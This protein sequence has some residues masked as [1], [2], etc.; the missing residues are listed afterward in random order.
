MTDDE[1]TSIG[2]ESPDGLRGPASTRAVTRESPAWRR[3][4]TAI[5]RLFRALDPYRGRLARLGVLSAIAVFFETLVLA[6]VVPLAGAISAN[7]KSLEASLGGVDLRISTWWLIGL[8]TSAVFVKLALGL[9]KGYAEARLLA[10]YEREQRLR[11][12]AAFLSS[13]WSV[14]SAEG[15]GHLQHVLTS[16]I[17]RCQTALRSLIGV[18]SAAAGL[19]VMLAGAFVAGGLSTLGIVIALVL[20]IA[21]SAPVLSRSRRHAREMLQLG[22]E[23]S[24]DLEESTTLVQEAR[25]FGARAALLE[26]IDASVRPFEY[27]RKR[28]WFLAQ[29]TSVFFETGGLL[30]VVG[31]LTTLYLLQPENLAGYTVMALLMARALMYGRQLNN[32][33]QACSDS[34]PF[35]LSLEAAV[36]KYEESKTAG[37]SEPIERIASIEFDDVSYAYVAAAPAL[38]EISARIETGQAIGVVGPSG[39]GK[40]TFLQLLLMLRTPSSGVIR[41]ND[42]DASTIDEGTWFGRTNLVPQH[43]R[44]FRGTVM[45]NIRFFRADVTDE[46]CI[47]AA[48]KAFLHDEIEQMPDGYATTLGARADAVSGGQRQRI[49]IAR[50]LAGNPDLLV[51]DEPTSAL[52]A[53][54]EEAIHR[55]LAALRGHTTLV[56]V[57]HRLTTIALCDKLMVLRDG[58]L[59][60]FGDRAAIESDSSYYAE[61]LR[62]SQVGDP[63]SR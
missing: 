24:G 7:K 62:L 20:L 18:I 44:L 35:V 29:A 42:L 40:S 26:R 6:A 11:G 45:D 1:P 37:G 5:A 43:P 41:V 49:C 50:A 14:Q 53:H 8:T 13:S 17:G 59:D 34:V 57:A 10:S 58:R 30:L 36:R 19:L 47:E 31:S 3:K 39:S 61:V 28:N 2:T 9:L 27:H 63:S 25:I 56:I 54:S 48:K 23:F 55:A 60:A 38:Q 22:Q 51:L 16:V 12:F 15:P 46:E 21:G 4:I 33:L 52:D 32:Q